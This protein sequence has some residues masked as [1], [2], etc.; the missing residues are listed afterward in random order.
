M[1][2]TQFFIISTG[3]AKYQHLELTVLLLVIKP[4]GFIPA[5]VN[6]SKDLDALKIQ[7]I[8]TIEG[9]DSILDGNYQARQHALSKCAVATLRKGFSVFAV[10]HGWWCASSD[11]AENTFD[12]YGK[13][14]TEVTV[15]EV[16][17]ET[18]FIYSVRINKLISLIYTDLKVFVGVASLDGLIYDM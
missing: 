13:Y 3:K 14:T 12:K 9:T 5:T 7:A 18:M 17:R 11:T 15:K 2:C 16:L 10:Q 6:I 4:V 1:D 8:P